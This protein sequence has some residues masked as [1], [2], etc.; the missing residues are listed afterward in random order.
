M[1]NYSRSVMKWENYLQANTLAGDIDTS[2]KR[3]PNSINS[4]ISNASQEIIDSNIANQKE[5]TRVL[6]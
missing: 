2:L 6:A 3:H 5:M 1:L 4:S